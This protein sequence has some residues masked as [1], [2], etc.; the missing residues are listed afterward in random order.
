M[1]V[2]CHM[3]S[4]FVSFPATEY[5]YAPVFCNHSLYGARDIGGIAWT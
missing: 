1:M 3:I 2:L 4:N 5:G